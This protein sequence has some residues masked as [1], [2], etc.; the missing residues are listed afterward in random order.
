MLFRVKL[1]SKPLSD[2][3]NRVGNHAEYKSKGKFQT[4]LNT[5]KASSLEITTYHRIT[6]PGFLTFLYIQTPPKLVFPQAL[7]NYARFALS[8]PIF[9][10]KSDPESGNLRAF[11]SL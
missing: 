8:T 3:T 2:M 7:L 4:N 9:Q 5:F 10:R 1:G 11:R 6:V